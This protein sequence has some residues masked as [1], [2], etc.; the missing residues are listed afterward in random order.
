MNHTVTV[1]VAITLAKGGFIDAA[2]ATLLAWDCYLRV[3]ELCSMTVKQVIMPHDSR[4]LRQSTRAVPD[5][6]RRF[7]PATIIALPH[8]KSGQAQ[9]VHIDNPNIDRLLITYLQHSNKRPCDKVFPYTTSSY[10]KMFHAAVAAL[11]MHDI[12]YTPHSLRHGGA[13]EF[14]MQHGPAALE[15]IQH[16]GRWVSASSLRTYIQ[17][18]SS[19]NIHNILPQQVIDIGNRFKQDILTSFL[20]Y[21]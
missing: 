8:N 4:N 20:P 19:V 11:Q 5:R 18:S 21:V 13:T 9:D 2:I 7:G 14:Y 6:L 3:S 12:P 16:R 15:Q 1:A 10:T 17:A